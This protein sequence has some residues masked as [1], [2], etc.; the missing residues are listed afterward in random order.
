[1]QSSTHPGHEFYQ[2]VNSPPKTGEEFLNWISTEPK[3]SLPSHDE[4]EFSPSFTPHE[5]AWIF[6][7]FVQN[8]MTHDPRYCEFFDQVNWSGQLKELPLCVQYPRGD[9]LIT[10]KGENHGFVL[11]KF[12]SDQNAHLSHKDTKAFDK[13]CS[14]HLGG[15]NLTKIYLVSTIKSFKLTTD[16]IIK[17]I[18]RDDL[19]SPVTDYTLAKI[20][21]D[22]DRASQMNLPLLVKEW[23]NQKELKSQEEECLKAQKEEAKLE[24][25]RKEQARKDKHYKKQIKKEKEKISESSDEEESSQR[26]K[27]RQSKKKARSKNIKK[28][29]Y[30][31]I[32]GTER[33][34][35][36]IVIQREIYQIHDD[37]GIIDLNY[38]TSGRR[39]RALYQQVS[40]RKYQVWPKLVKDL[41]S[42]IGSVLRELSKMNIV[43]K[44][45][46]VWVFCHPISKKDSFHQLPWEK[47]W[48]HIKTFSTLFNRFPEQKDAV[49]PILTQLW[50]ARQQIDYAIDRRIIL[51]EP[52]PDDQEEEETDFNPESFLQETCSFIN[53]NG[54][55]FSDRNLPVLLPIAS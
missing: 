49:N 44:E 34:G 7:Y 10:T 50:L 23:K 27:K 4:E 45:H 3:S 28:K 36:R 19:L 37:Q 42:R 43:K 51:V 29:F 53:Q 35:W 52:T 46:D 31:H 22:D 39:G 12:R 48:D 14:N 32:E 21:G 11:S 30:Y 38:M 47:K 26:P 1:M 20:F 54:N 33:V 8:L 15:C 17:T 16:S 55:L 5:K 24:K 41:R 25:A 40:T 9:L 6:N 2:N 18:L 13:I